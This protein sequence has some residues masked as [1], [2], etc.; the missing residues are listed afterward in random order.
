VGL[1]AGTGIA[2]ISPIGGYIRLRRGDTSMQQVFVTDQDI[3]LSLD[4]G[5]TWRRVAIPGSDRDLAYAQT[6]EVFG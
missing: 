5:A 6:I 2:P 3:W 1:L 4:F